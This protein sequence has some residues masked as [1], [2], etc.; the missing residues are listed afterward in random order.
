MIPV[1]CCFP[2]DLMHL[3]F[4]NLGELLIPLWRGTIKCDATD[5]PTSWEWA[6]LTGDIWQAHGRLVADVTPFFPSSFHRPPCNPVEKISSGYKAIEYFHYLFGLGPGIFV[7]FFHQNTGRISA[8]L[9][10]AF[11]LSL[12]EVSWVP[13]CKRCTQN[14]SSLL[15]NLRICTISSVL[16]AFISVTH[17]FIPSS[18]LLLR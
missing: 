5:S 17:A 8:S 13:S 6:T 16:I 7:P 4:I 10:V 1:P 3:V 9:F 14:L 11:E 2:L 12:T 15:K 18:I